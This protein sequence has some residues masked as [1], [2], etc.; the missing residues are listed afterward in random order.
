MTKVHTYLRL[1]YLLIY[2]YARLFVHILI[3]LLCRLSWG[4][5]WSRFTCQSQATSC[6]PCQPYRPVH[7]SSRRV[8]WVEWPWLH[9]GTNPSWPILSPTGDRIRSKVELTRYL[10]PAC[11]LTLFD[12]KQGILCYPAPKVLH[13]VGYPAGMTEPPNTHPLISSFFS[14]HLQPQSLPVPSRKRKKP[15]R[16]AKTRKRQVGPQKG[17]VRKEAPGDETKADADTAPASLPAPGWVLT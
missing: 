7:Q 14:S 10:G 5:I 16:P 8:V 17:E 6:I 1:Y 12:F 15:S 13:S 11:D 2:A 9:P 4:T 3:F